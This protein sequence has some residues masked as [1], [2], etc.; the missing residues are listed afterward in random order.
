MEI[1]GGPR[2]V[3]NER[4]TYAVAERAFDSQFLHEQKGNWDRD[5]RASHAELE[6]CTQG[7]TRTLIPADIIDWSH[8][9][10]RPTNL[11]DQQRHLYAH[12]CA[13]RIDND[14]QALLTT[15]VDTELLLEEAEKLLAV[16]L[17]PLGVDITQADLYHLHCSTQSVLSQEEY[18]RW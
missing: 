8:L 1:R 13:T 15:L 2:R 3:R 10:E 11:R 9:D 16:D 12:L 17:V 7:Q 5:F 18:S 6:Q 14:V 4:R